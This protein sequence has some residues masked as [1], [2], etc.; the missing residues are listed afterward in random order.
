[1]DNPTTPGSSAPTPR[2]PSGPSPAP[3]T[4]GVRRGSPSVVGDGVQQR[5]RVRGGSHRRQLL[6][7]HPSHGPRPR[8]S[9]RR[10]PGR[11]A[12]FRRRWRSLVTNSPV[13][14]NRMK[15]FNPT[16]HA[17]RPAVSES[18]SA[19]HTSLVRCDI[20]WTGVPEVR[21]SRRPSSVSRNR[22][23][24]A[25]ARESAQ[26]SNGVIGRRAASRPIRPCMAVETPIPTRSAA[27]EQTRHFG[28][29]GPDSAPHH[30]RVLHLPAGLGLL[31]RVLVDCAGTPA[32]A[33][34]EGGHLGRRG[35]DVE[36]DHNPGALGRAAHLSRPTARPARGCRPWSRD[37]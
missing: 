18:S 9:S 6:A 12:R 20:E 22:I 16:H 35:A 29:A 26:V 34:G 8:R 33:E 24:C 5:Q 19:N 28:Q 17:A 25:A 7:A 32:T 37:R 36:A 13:N 30:L 31:Q 2:F 1:M 23:A 3:R 21:C 10:S 4:T 14:C 27:G 11:E 15:S